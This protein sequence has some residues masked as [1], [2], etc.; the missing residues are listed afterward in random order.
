M[1]KENDMP[2]RASS[3]P[4]EAQLEVLNILWQNGP[5]T[6]RQVH[7]ILQG[8]RRTGLTTTLKIL[9]VMTDKGL[10][11]RDEGVRPHRYRPAASEAR[12]QT[13]LLADRARR[14]FGG[15]VGKMFVRAVEEGQLTGEEL[16]RIRALI[17]ETRKSKQR[18]RE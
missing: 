12:T 18:G 3:Q 7:E 11:V 15:S 2:R 1:Q 8:D 9:Q 13:G 14:A 17:D 6:V 4:T 5:S 16:A 10:T